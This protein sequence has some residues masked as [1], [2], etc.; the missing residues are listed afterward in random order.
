MNQR[1]H[2]T[3]TRILINCIALLF[4]KTK[5]WLISMYFLHRKFPSHGEID[6]LEERVGDRLRRCL[7]R[8][9]GAG[10]S[11]L[12]RLYQHGTGN[13]EVQRRFVTT[14]CSVLRKMCWT[15]WNPVPMSWECSKEQEPTG[16]DFRVPCGS[17]LTGPLHYFPG[18]Q[19]SRHNAHLQCG[20]QRQG[21]TI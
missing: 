6:S 4:L 17:G 3:N 21:L 15:R 9:I 2:K 12:S 5:I 14:I 1:A 11:A 13:N 18:P 7:V 16:T 20:N 8:G 19:Y 10:I